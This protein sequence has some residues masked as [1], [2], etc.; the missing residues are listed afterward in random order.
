MPVRYMTASRRVFDG[1]VPEL[2][3][4]PPT[5]CCCSTTATRRRSL[6]AWMAAFCPAG[7]EPITSRSK[8]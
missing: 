1:I 7:P 4:T 6:A 3:H 8:S 5:I 2:M